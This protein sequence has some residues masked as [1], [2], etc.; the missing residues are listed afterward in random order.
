MKVAI[1][2]SGGRE[3][4]IAWKIAQTEGW[5]NVFTLPGNGGIPNSHI[6]DTNNFG[7]VEVFCRQNNIQ[8]IVV[9]PEI[10][11]SAGIVDYFRQTD[12]LILGPTKQAALLEGSKIWA[13]QFMQKYGVATAASQTFKSVDSAVSF[14]QSLQNKCVIKY[15][16][17]AAGKGVFVCNTANDVEEAF[18][19]LTTQY[20]NEFPFLVEELL[21]G[22]EISIIGITNGKAIRLLQPSQDHKQLLDN[23]LGPNTGGMGA[24]C[25]VPFCNDALM[26][27]IEAD[28]VTPTL[29][30]LQAEGLDYKG[31]IYFGLMITDKG[32]KALEYNARL[33]DPETE[34]ILPSLKSDLLPLILACLNNTL[35]DHTLA[36]HEGFFVDVVLTSGGYPKQY[37]QGY[38]ISGLDKVSPNTLVFHA[39]TAKQANQIVT[40]GG[41][42]LNIVGHGKNLSEA[43]EKAYQG[44][45]KVSFTDVYYRKDIGQR[46]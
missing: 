18:N 40:K 37:K 39:G 41:R 9:G 1:I 10:P 45:A 2:G 44:V 33:G 28:I 15:D 8:L 22:D 30:G 20:G 26:Q 13:K 42:V 27:Q 12:I 5:D 11:L 23:D 46:K 4:A 25:P 43:I 34:V 16:G 7:E 31:F 14:I 19:D 6:V 29:N 21:L 24:F 3:H 32:P 36:F 17:L 35:A 38:P